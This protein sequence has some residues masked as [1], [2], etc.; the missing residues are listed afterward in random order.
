MFIVFKVLALS[1][2]YSLNIRNK[3][4]I[5][6]TAMTTIAR[7]KVYFHDLQFDEM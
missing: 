2:H 1:L 6:K 5:Y 3:N 4:T 7:G